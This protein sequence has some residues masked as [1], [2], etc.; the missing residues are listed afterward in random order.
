MR[1]GQ[2]PAVHH[3]SLPAAGCAGARSG[4]D[5][6]LLRARGQAEN[7]ARALP[8]DEG[9]PPFLVVVDVGNVIEL[10]AEFSRSGATYVPFPDP[11]SHRIRLADLRDEAVRARLAAVWLDPLSLDP[12]RHAARVT[13]EI[14]GHLAALAK[15]L[16]EAG[17]APEPSPASSPAACSAC[18]PRMSA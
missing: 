1:T 10:Y 6:A 17:H 3:R 7:Y 5:D 14:A 8:A 12:T 11:R 9:R 2:L 15:L 13:R 16:E 4:F 18:S